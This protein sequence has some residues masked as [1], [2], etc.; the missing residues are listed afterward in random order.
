MSVGER[1]AGAESWRRLVGRC[2]GVVTCCDIGG[3]EGK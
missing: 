2:S 1:G 3:R